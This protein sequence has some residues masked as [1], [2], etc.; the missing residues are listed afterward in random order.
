MTDTIDP[1]ELANELA[2][3]EAL[4]RFNDEPFRPIAE[5]DGTTLAILSDGTNWT[6]GCRYRGKWCSMF[7]GDYTSK[8]G[9][10]PTQFKIVPGELLV[11]YAH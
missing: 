9:F 3:Q 1:A 11:A 5:Y 4:L 8:Q 6:F 7:D 2:E 10:G